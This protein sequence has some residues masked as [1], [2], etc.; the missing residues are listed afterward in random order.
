MT[1]EQ[2]LADLSM[3]LPDIA[4]PVGAYL[5]CVRTGNLVFV[6]GQIPMR[7]G[8][9][10]CQGKVGADVTIAQA[11]QAAQI[12]CV[13]ALA[14]VKAE[15]GSLENVTRVVRME[16][17]VSSAPGFTDQVQVANAA[18]QLLQNVFGTAGR[19]A[20][21]AVGVAELPL[22]APVELAFVFEVS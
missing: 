10:V 15:V 8:Q 9:L 2:K 16:V 7:D 3:K 14:A 17:F 18:S 1:V 21:L 22:N 11:V 6:S 19:H 4:A 13:N 12:A 20:R 5:P